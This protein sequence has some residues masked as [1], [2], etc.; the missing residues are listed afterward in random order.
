[1]VL[2]P[3]ATSELPDGP[4]DLATWREH[5]REEEPI[6]PPIKFQT[7]PESRPKPSRPVDLALAGQDAQGPG[8]DPGRVGPNAHSQ[9]SA[10][11]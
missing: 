7:P 4:T 11:P 10:R 1:M 5:F 8:A 6:P 9:P 2:D 3:E